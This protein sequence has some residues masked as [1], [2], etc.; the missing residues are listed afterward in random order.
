MPPVRLLGS[1][2]LSW[3]TRLASGYWHVGD[4]QCGYTVASRRALLAIGAD[5]F[6]RYGYPN[7]LLARL[8]G[9]ARARRRRAGAARSTGPAGARGCA[10]CAW[11]CRSPGC[12]CA[13]SA[14]ACA[15]AGA[16]R[17][18]RAGAGR[19]RGRRGVARAVMSDRPPHDVVPAPRRAT[20][21]AASSAIACGGCS[22]TGTRVDVLAAGDG[23]AAREMEHEA[24]LTRDAPRLTRSPRT[25][26]RVCSTARAR[27][28]RWSAGGARVWLAAA[29]FSAALAAAAARAR[30]SLRRRRIALA[31]SERAR[32]A[33]RRA[34]R[35][36]SA[37]SRTRA[38]SRCS[39]AS[40]SG[41][42]S[43]AA[44]SAPG[45]ELR[46]VSDELRARFAALAGAGAV[47][48]VEP[49]RAPGAN[50]RRGAGVDVARPAA[51]R[52][53]AA[54]RCSRS[55]GW[56]RSRATIGCCA[57]ARACSATAAPTRPLEVVILGDGPERDRLGRLADAL[58]VRLRLPGFVPRARS[59]A[60]C[61]PPTSTCSR[62]SGCRTAAAK[63]APIATA[64]ARAVGIPVL[65]DSDVGSRW[66]EGLAAADFTRSRQACN[67]IRTFSA[68]PRSALRGCRVCASR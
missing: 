36:A 50:G 61:A 51:A 64:E 17:P 28:R 22:P 4:S 44:S 23:G 45:V 3:L 52:P 5:L 18:R 24:R 55:A 33:R 27:P 54:R 19:G 42:R 10:R 60:G 2:V 37:R 7:D 21:R 41:A 59:R 43:P 32:R 48:T 56:F 8:G 31:G 46:F 13:G 9:G 62:R 65:V 57:R 39:S 68:W 29:R 16:G 15:R 53:R 26:R 66:R 30:A 38:T 35:T 63:G 34:R 67:Q 58:G 49:L 14:G 47:G 11:R 1:V 25:E 6:P 20:T 12:C 40:R